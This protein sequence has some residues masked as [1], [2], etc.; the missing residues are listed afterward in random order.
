MNLHIELLKLH[1]NTLLAKHLEQWKTLEIVLCNYWWS[2]IS[3]NIKKYVQECN[4][5]QQNKAVRKPLYNLL[6][7]N[8]IPTGPSKI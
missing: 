7:P 6:H 1:H 8:K 2:E 5:C 4:T 3:V